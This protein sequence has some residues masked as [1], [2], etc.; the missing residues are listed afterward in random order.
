MTSIGRRIFVFVSTSCKTIVIFVQAWF[1]V[2]FCVV[3][4]LAYLAA[5]GWCALRLFCHPL[6]ARFSMPFDVWL[7]IGAVTIHLG[8]LAVGLWLVGGLAFGFFSAVSFASSLMA[9]L[10]V[11]S[12]FSKPIENLGVVV[13]PLAALGLGLATWMPVPAVLPNSAGWGLGVHVLA[14]LLAYALLFLAAVQAVF[15]AILD[16]QLRRRHASRFM[17]SMPPLQ[18]MEALLFE[19]IGLGFAILSV[20]L[21][22]GF[23]FLHDIFAQHLVHKSVLSVCAWLLFA[24]LL[25]GRWRCGWRGRTA[26]RWTLSGFVLLLLAYF[27]SKAV[28]ELIL[29]V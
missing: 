7:G 25:W 29:A 22:V 19:L 17:R 14:S 4:M 8:C 12:A 15:L 26:I 11:L 16:R 1:M 24:G 9:G 28:L 13:F 27:G 23:A 2:I 18:S 10:F 20:A 3:A 5:A 21:L 6:S